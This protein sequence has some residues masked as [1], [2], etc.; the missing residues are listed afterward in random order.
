M[1]LNP[2][3][4]VEQLHVDSIVVEGRGLSRYVMDEQNTFDVRG[5]G[6]T[7][8]HVRIILSDGADL[9]S[10]VDAAQ[11]VVTVVYRVQV[12]TDVSITI[13]ITETFRSNYT[14]AAGLSFSAAFT[15]L[16]S[17]P[18]LS[19]QTLC[20]LEDYGHNRDVVLLAASCTKSR[21]RPTLKQRA[22][23]Q[24]IKTATSYHLLDARLVLTVLDKCFVSLF[25]GHCG[26]VSA[27]ADNIYTVM[28]A[29]QTSSQIQA[30]ACWT[31]WWIGHTSV[32]CKLILLKGRAMEVCL[33]AMA[34]CPQCQYPRESV[35]FLRA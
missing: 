7:S 8:S 6:L 22:L 35:N 9:L 20:V 28:D 33:R 31:I 5:T 34:V 4:K 13:A 15:W 12:N 25:Q 30:E 32:E 11:G 2:V 21:A 27:I 19:K 17:K 23:L 1:K 24:L 26:N 10:V 16:S 14:A 18:P 3:V 29:H